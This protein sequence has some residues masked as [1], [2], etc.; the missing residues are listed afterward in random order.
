MSE[1]QPSGVS[2]ENKRDT[3]PDNIKNLDQAG[4]QVVKDIKRARRD[5]KIFRRRSASI[6]A[7]EKQKMPKNKRRG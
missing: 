3:R 6:R 1:N 5:W 2:G 7:A 4:E